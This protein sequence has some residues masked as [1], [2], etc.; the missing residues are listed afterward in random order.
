MSVITNIATALPAHKHKQGDLANFMGK[1]FSYN[2]NE[3]KK[4]TTLFA[5]SAIEYRY[6]SIP[7]YSCNIDERIFYPK[8]DN[9]EPFPSVE[10][11]M[12][13]FNKMALP[14][15]LEAIEKC[16]KDNIRLEE[17]TH[18]ITVSCTGLSAPGLDID[19]VQ[20]L[21]L[22]S[23]INR[24]SINFMG[25]YAALHALKQ[26]DYICTSDANAVVLI[27]CV[28]LCTIH[29]QKN[30]D[31]ENIT[32]SLLFADGAAA[33]LMVGN[34][35]HTNNNLNGLAIK[36]FNSQI[37]LKGKGDMAW[38]IS[39]TGFLMTLSS[40]IP[41]LI[42]H[43]FKSLFQKS[44]ANLDITKDEIKHWAIHP[45]GRKILE[46]VQHELSLNKEDLESSYKVLKNY[47]NMSSPTILFVLKDI[48]ENKV[49]KAKKEL[50]YGIAFGPGLTMESVILENV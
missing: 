13:Y 40:Y 41:Q 44:I 21:Q 33:A 26:A 49:D 27:V 2:D 36:K 32:A 38:Q 30:N 15:C 10:F 16:I 46:V 42:E 17:V 48:L 22:N 14:L 9:L 47:G 3:R 20:Q 7:D 28:E 8:T 12:D 23:N 6:S 43:G 35:Y 29:F 34:N 31:I 5:K 4:L 11:R 1:L 25:C 50:I 18:L 24:T 39:S 19:I 37:D 45:G